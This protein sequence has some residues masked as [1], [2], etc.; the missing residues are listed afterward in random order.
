[1]PNEQIWKNVKDSLITPA[2]KELRK[3]G[4][5]C[6]MNFACCNTCASADLDE[7][8]KEK[9]NPAFIYWHHQEEAR[10]TE[11][12]AGST[13]SLGFASALEEDELSTLDV[14]KALCEELMKA[15]IRYRDQRSDRL[16]DFE[17]AI[18]W[19]WSEGQKVQVRWNPKRSS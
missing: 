19:N 15:N 16:F 3:R 17:A 13:L 2:F 14:G 9:K 6:R 4:Y 5:L 11:W 1:M 7:K 18:D 8:A 12:D 10:Q